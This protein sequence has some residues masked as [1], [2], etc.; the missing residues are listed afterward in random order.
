[1]SDELENLWQKIKTQRDELRVQGHL[2][3]AEL[4]DEWRDLELKW[5]T[6][7]KN[8]QHLQSE[9]K[10]TTDEWRSS[11]KVVMEELSAAYDRIKGRLG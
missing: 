4:E 8:L 10:E 7:E 3:K 11:A 1:M 2:A 9:A 5:E 6:A